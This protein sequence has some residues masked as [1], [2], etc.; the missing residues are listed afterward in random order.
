MEH[1]TLDGEV[2]ETAAGNR[3]PLQI[4]LSE[5]AAFK[6]KLVETVAADP[7]LSKAPCASAIVVLMS[8]VT[9][10]KRTLKPTT[11]YASITTLMAKGGMKRTAATDARRLLVKEGYLEPTGSKTKDGCVKYRL[12]NPNAER[13]QMHVHEAMEYWQ[14]CAAE[15]R[16]DERRKRAGQHDVVPEYDTT[17]NTCGASGQHDVVPEYD[18]NYL[19]EYLSGLGNEKKDNL[20]GS[21]VSGYGSASGRLDDRFIAFDPPDDD[22]DAS[23]LIM[24]WLE[25]QPKHVV[26]DLFEVIRDRLYSGTFTPAELDALLG[27]AAA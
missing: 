17:E 1:V 21:S 25:G 2:I 3:S 16:A 9:I 14:E 4:A 12:A 24:S 19:R 18:T 20:Q 6:F 5:L 13:V 23:D 10:D 22:G 11:A 7:R 26:I 15:R 8:F 27:R